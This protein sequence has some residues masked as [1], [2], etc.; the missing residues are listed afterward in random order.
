MCSVAV[1]LLF[2]LGG[3]RTQIAGCGIDSRH[4]LSLGHTYSRS[5]AVAV[6][7]S[8]QLARVLGL[9]WIVAERIIVVPAAHDFAIA[10]PRPLVHTLARGV[11]RRLL[12]N[13]AT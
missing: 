8:R 3:R 5:V 6:T 7:A 12:G 2:V 13:L 4:R 11:L 1:V 9:T 10:G